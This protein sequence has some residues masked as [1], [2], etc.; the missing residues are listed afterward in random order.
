[1]KV[2]RT[3]NKWVAQV[4]ILRP[5]CLLA[6]R[7]KPRHPGLK[8]E[9]W[10]THS[11]SGSCGLFVWGLDALSAKAFGNCKVQ[12][13][14]LTDNWTVAHDRAQR[15]C[16]YENQHI[17]KGS[18]LLD[19]VADD[20]RRRDPGQVP[21]QIEKRAVESHHALRRSIRDHRPP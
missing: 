12:P 1:M 8:I 14:D 6:R 4:S 19:Q 16:P 3:T 15:G 18:G 13:I 5:G 9:T 20:N 11:L 7:F 21:D 17:V 2:A 10:A